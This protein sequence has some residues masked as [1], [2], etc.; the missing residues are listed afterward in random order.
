MNEKHQRGRHSGTCCLFSWNRHA[1]KLTE[2]SAVIGGRF[3]LKVD[4]NTKTL[5]SLD[6]PTQKPAVLVAGKVV[7][8]CSSSSETQSG[9]PSLVTEGKWC[10][11]TRHQRKVVCLHSSPK[12]NSAVSSP[13]PTNKQKCL[14]LSRFVEHGC[15]RSLPTKEKLRV[16]VYHQRWNSGVFAHCQ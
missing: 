16:F 3:I 13:S 4:E 14:R 5:Q 10:A 6:I 2:K 1:G 7:V 11:F 15:L 8:T 12:R 9:V